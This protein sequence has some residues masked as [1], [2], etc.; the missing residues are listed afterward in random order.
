MNEGRNEI[1]FRELR[2]HSRNLLRI[3]TGTFCREVQE[4]REVMR[5]KLLD[6]ES[7]LRTSLLEIREMAKRRFLEL[8]RIGDTLTCEYLRAVCADVSFLLTAFEPARKGG[9]SS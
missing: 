1:L 5:A 9:A 2:R 8:D 4:F 7:D 6:R 3:N